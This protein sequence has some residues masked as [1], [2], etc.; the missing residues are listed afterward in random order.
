MRRQVL[1]IL[2]FCSALV[3]AG[4]VIAGTGGFLP[5]GNMLSARFR[6]TLTLLPDGRVLAAGGLS[7]C[8]P[9]L[10]LA[11][12]E[13][14]DPI[15]GT[16]SATGNMSNG[17][18]F[19]TA[20]LLQSGKV[21][22][23]GGHNGT[24]P[25]VS[26]DLYDP[27]TGAFLT[28]G[29]LNTPRAGHGA[30]LLP[31]GKVLV[32]GGYFNGSLASAELYDPTAGTFTPAGNMTAA[33]Y[34]HTATLLPSGK[35]LLAGGVDAANTAELY[36]PSTGSFT[37]TGSMNMPRWR[38]TA[39]LLADG[40]VL[41]T[42]ILPFGSGG[43]TAEIYDPGTGS[44]SPTGNM[45]VPRWGHQATVLQ[46]GTVLITGGAAGA[47]LYSPQTGTF[48]SAGVLAIGAAA[49]TLLQNGE[50]LVTGAPEFVTEVSATAEIWSTSVVSPPTIYN[51]DPGSTIQNGPAFDLTI[52]GSDFASGAT[53]QWNGS[54]RATTVVNDW[55]LT[56]SINAADIASSAEFYST[57]AVT[58][59]N[60]EMERCRFRQHSLF[61]ILT[62]SELR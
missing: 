54:P 1:D 61:G 28:T 50:V 36:D 35:V 18:E 20:T 48:G 42:G 31:N 17:R 13:L 57:A 49:A 41:V 27:A 45:G 38:H 29:N 9:T 33:R 21:L 22:V 39:S 52:N 15:S 43:P 2:L 12:A 47:E 23:V 4:D 44:F 34:F 37:T 10:Y 11:S 6:N 32:T 3:L 55:Q 58:V 40:K 46:D 60:P 53:L 24:N 19:G 5:T 59:L 26:A 25:N 51:L 14:Y 56:A 16:F 7:P 62:F 8:C 30:T